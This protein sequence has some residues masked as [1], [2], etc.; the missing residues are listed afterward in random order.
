[1]ILRFLLEKEFKQVTRD[2]FLPAMIVGFPTMMMLLLPWAANLEVENI[3]LSVVDRDRSPLS[4]QLVRALDA[5][6]Y[7]RL[8]ELPASFPLSL[9][10]VAAGRSDVVLDIPP[11]F[12]NDLEREGRARVFIAPNSVNGTKGGLAAAYL[13]TILEGFAA[14]LREG[15]PAAE[16]VEVMTL[17][18]FNP[19]LEYKPFMVPALMVMLLMLLCGFLPALNI[20]GEKE[21]GTIEQI[22]VTPVGKFTFILAKLI[23]YWVIGFAILTYSFGLAYLFYGI[24][25]AG[26]LGTIYLFAALFVLGIAGFGLIVSN[27]SATMQ[28]AMF[29]MFFFLMLFVL[30]C[31]IFSP[32]ESMPGW[33][34]AIA[35]F[36][37]LKYFVQVTRA[38]YLKGSGVSDLTGQLLAL[39]IFAV[40]MNAWAVWGYRKSR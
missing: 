30:M 19:R 18:R 36:N 24:A 20:V 27:H 6:N 8:V 26:S 17:N 11:R 3:H 39:G 1:M 9:E 5:S 40:V 23:P 32:V 14:T 25:P 13:S 38:V 22:N 12:G 7:F 35:A 29:V 10:G 4:G 31:G 37:P 15:V 2:A 28:Q 33:A 21:R 16:A 34:R